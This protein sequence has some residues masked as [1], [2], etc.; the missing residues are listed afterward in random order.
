MPAISFAAGDTFT[1]TVTV[2]AAGSLE[3]IAPLWGT[4]ELEFGGETTS[5][6][7][8]DATAGK[9]DLSMASIVKLATV[10]ENCLPCCTPCI[11]M[12]LVRTSCLS[13]Q[14]WENHHL[15]RI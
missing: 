13:C 3:G 8:A 15:C 6:L 2:S 7:Y 1:G 9:L 11:R 14:G 5:P 10:R 4:F 12:F